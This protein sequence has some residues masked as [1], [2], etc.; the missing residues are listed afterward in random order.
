[1][2]FNCQSQT[3]AEEDFELGGSQMEGAEVE[4]RA[5]MSL[6]PFPSQAQDGIET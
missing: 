1:M 3:K 4:E 2:G 6:P 5:E